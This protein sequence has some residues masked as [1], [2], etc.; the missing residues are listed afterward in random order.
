M[1]AWVHGHEALLWWMGILS[2]LSFFGTLTAVPF[3]VARI[4]ADYFS[5][6]QRFVQNGRV[7]ISGPH[8]AGS[9]LKNVIGLMF[10]LVG[11]AMLVLPGQGIITILL[12]LFL[13]NFPGKRQL[14]RRI[15]GA[16]A[17]LKGINWMRKR[18]NQPPLQM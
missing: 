18:G 17:V 14:E 13:M 8:V 15:V 11:V 10:V 4:P 5:R 2:I 12:G 9:I 7:K 1:F 3:L 16:P 6:T